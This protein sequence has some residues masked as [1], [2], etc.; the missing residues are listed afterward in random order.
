LIEDYLSKEK[1]SLGI[2]ANIA[3]TSE[4]DFEQGLGDSIRQIGATF[5]D[6]ISIILIGT[7]VVLVIHTKKT[8]IQL[9]CVYCLIAFLLVLLLCARRIVQYMHYI[10]VYMNSQHML[11]TDISIQVF[12]DTPK[13]ARKTRKLVTFEDRS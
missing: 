3:A 5:Q 6:I 7:K 9:I 2:V 8:I 11:N 1:S 10:H 4:R 12:F 13:N